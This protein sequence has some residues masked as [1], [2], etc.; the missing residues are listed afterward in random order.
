M[1]PIEPIDSDAIWTRV[2]LQEL[3]RSLA[4]VEQSIAIF[5][6]ALQGLP[7]CNTCARSQLLQRLQ[8]ASN[9]LGRE[10]ISVSMLAET[11]KQAMATAERAQHSLTTP[12]PSPCR[13]VAE[14]CRC[15]S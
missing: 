4:T 10:S 3:R 7:S 1:P 12:P 2:G 14:P 6:R 13:C 11:L 15:H 8:A 9:H 5:E